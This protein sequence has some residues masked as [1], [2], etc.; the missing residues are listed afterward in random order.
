MTFIR[1]SARIRS[2]RA[3]TVAGLTAALA[4][5]AAAC[6]GNSSGMQSMPGMQPSAMPPAGTQSM[7]GMAGM[8]EMPAGD[9]TTDQASGFRLNLL[10]TSLPA[11][12]PDTLQFR[13]T[14]TDGKPV[15]RFQEDQTKLLHF[16][17]IRSDL[18]EFQHVHPT[19]A[20]DGT[21]SARLAA[22]TAGTYRAYTQ[23]ITPDASGKPVSL[24][25][26]QRVTVPGATRPT[27]LPPPSN[28]TEVDGYT[29]NLQG[30]PMSG[31]SNPLTVTITKDGRPV[32]DLQPYLDTY[33]HLTAF[34]DGDLAF[35]HLHPQGDVNGD[36]GGPRLQFDALFP[37][38]GAWR[39]FLQFQ[40]GGVLHTAAVTVQV[41]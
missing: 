40:T 4:L 21:W 17:L 30:Q 19:M 39:L 37:K 3:L 23:F 28:M 7:P 15:T 34:H 38:P 29:L 14:T 26:S 2:P 31:M 12:K 10:N 13:I 41:G 33:A 8:D 24:V 16:Y 20:A 9:G 32:T 22:T 11:G 25:L 36:H 35:A 6:G 5:T 27:P 18:T 1:M